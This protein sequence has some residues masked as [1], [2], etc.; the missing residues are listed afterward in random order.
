MNDTLYYNEYWLNDAAVRLRR[1]RQQLERLRDLLCAVRAASGPEYAADITL[2]LRKVERLERSL[3]Q[4]RNALEQFR[5]EMELENRRAG[6]AYEDAGA[7]A[8]RVFA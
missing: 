3:T 1:E 7:R 5:D 8:R 6:A 4:T 2:I